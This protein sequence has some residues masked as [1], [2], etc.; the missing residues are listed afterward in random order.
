MNYGEHPINVPPLHIDELTEDSTAYERVVAA[1][2]DDERVFMWSLWSG[3]AFAS[4]AVTFT[5]FFGILSNAKARRSPFNQYLLYLMMPDI[6]Y[7]FICGID[8][9][10]NAIQGQYVSSVTCYI[11]SWY[12]MFGVSG[13]AYMNAVLAREIHHMLSF[14]Q[15][16][17]RYQPPTSIDIAKRSAFALCFAAFVST[18]GNWQVPWLPHHTVLVGGIACF[19][20]DFDTSTSLFFYLVFFPFL[21]AIPMGYVIFLALQIWYKD[22]IPKRGRR[23][24]LAIFILRLMAVYI[25]M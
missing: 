9:L 13:S 14:G 10:R 23:K 7:S 16:F 25:V 12:A 18:W 19:P 20:Q 22:M 11:Q 8:C 4:A 24:M 21:L 3:V 17:R 5:A 1:P 2:S 6:V 15:E